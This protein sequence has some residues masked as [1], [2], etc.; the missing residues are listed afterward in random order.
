[1]ALVITV[2]GAQFRED[3]WEQPQSSESQMHREVE[4]LVVGSHQVLPESHVGG[5]IPLAPQ[6]CRVPC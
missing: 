5:I 4:L 6:A 1:M 2:T 3:P